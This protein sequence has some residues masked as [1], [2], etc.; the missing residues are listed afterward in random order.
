MK[1]GWYLPVY[2]LMALNVVIAVVA[3]AILPETVPFRWDMLTGEAYESGMRSKWF[4]A[5][6]PVITTA[7]GIFI[8]ATVTPKNEK[9]WIFTAIVV[10]IVYNIITIW[11][12]VTQLSFVA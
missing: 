9:E 3:I 8:L 2:V 11:I 1:K 4:H 10:L 12:L 5:M 6:S 7:V